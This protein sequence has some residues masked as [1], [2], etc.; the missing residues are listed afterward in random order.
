LRL[1]G[2]QAARTRRT[3]ELT[4]PLILVSELKREYQQVASALTELLAKDRV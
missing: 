2:G 4:E 3:G 1:S